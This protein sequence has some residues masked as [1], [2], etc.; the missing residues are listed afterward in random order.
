M[1]LYCVMAE[2]LIYQRRFLGF[3]CSVKDEIYSEAY[4]AKLKKLLIAHSF[5]DIEL[6]IHL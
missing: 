2:I 1:Q 4:N 6:G 3:D 5:F